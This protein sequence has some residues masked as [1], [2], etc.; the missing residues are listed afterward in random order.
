MIEFRKLERR[1][2]PLMHRWLNTPHVV[3]WWPDEALPLDEIVAKY[4][5]RIYGFEHLRCFLIV[6]CD[7]PIGYIQEYPVDEKSV[8]KRVEFE[9]SV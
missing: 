5:P 7:M 4:T 1:D 9:T 8:G 3:E 2:L 6:H